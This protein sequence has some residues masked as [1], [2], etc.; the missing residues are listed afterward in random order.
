MLRVQR[1][2]NKGGQFSLKRVSP[3]PNEL[4]CARSGLGVIFPGVYLGNCVHFTLWG[5]GINDLHHESVMHKV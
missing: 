4:S 3:G 5:K 1:G 2:K